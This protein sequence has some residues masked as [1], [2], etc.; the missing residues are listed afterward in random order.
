M[1]HEYAVGDIVDIGG[2]YTRRMVVV[3]VARNIAG[4]IIA[5]QCR[6][7]STNRGL[8]ILLSAWGVTPVSDDEALDA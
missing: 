2:E 4:E 1:A 6:D 8:W 5:V 7:Q 3:D